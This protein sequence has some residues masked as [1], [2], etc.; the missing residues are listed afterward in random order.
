MA[1]RL[2]T[3]RIVLACSQWLDACLVNLHA[4]ASP[5]LGH[6][7]LMSLFA[8]FFRVFND[9]LHSGSWLPIQDRWVLVERVTMEAVD[10]IEGLGPSPT[11]I[12][13]DEVDAIALMYDHLLREITL[14]M[15]V[16]VLK[17]DSELAFE[18]LVGH[19]LLLTYRGPY[20]W[21]EASSSQQ[22]LI[23]ERRFDQE[24]E[25]EDRYLTL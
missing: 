25:N 8:L 18:R 22:R 7:D 23:R 21:V 9:S 24:C 1:R 15:D 14:S 4:H 13:S 2:Q 11:E 19:D 20:P 17:P 6:G 16:S 5:A 3:Q 10:W 12:E